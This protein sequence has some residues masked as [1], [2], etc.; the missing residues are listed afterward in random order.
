MSWN[1]LVYVFTTEYEKICKIKVSA[2]SKCLSKQIL[3]LCAKLFNNCIFV[4]YKNVNLLINL[5]P[6]YHDVHI[7]TYFYN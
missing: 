6:N 1:I 4:F 2:F 5:R 3:H 7:C